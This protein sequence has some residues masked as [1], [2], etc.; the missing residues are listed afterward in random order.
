M[1]SRNKLL[2]CYYGTKENSNSIK[3]IENCWSETFQVINYYKCAN[4]TTDDLY[5]NLWKCG[6]EKMDI[7]IN[8][9]NN[10][11]TIVAINTDNE[12]VVEHLTDIKKF[13]LLLNPKNLFET[14]KNTL[15][16]SLGS[17]IKGCRTGINP[18]LFYCDSV[19][20]GLA[21]NFGVVRKKVEQDFYSS[22]TYKPLLEVKDSLLNNDVYFYNFLKTIKIKTECINYENRG[23]FKRTA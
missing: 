14:K 3:L 9:R 22:L 23:L 13:H 21:I 2:V 20:F 12:E 4:T 8:E 5:F 18:S 10:F 15:Y 6:I 16:Y 11:S 19:T 1:T 7:E 17:F